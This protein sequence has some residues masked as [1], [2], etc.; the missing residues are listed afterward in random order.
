M[1]FG[2]NGTRCYRLSRLQSRKGL[3]PKTPVQPN[4][5]GTAPITQPGNTARTV[6]RFQARCSAWPC[7]R[8]LEPGRLAQGQALIW[9]D[10]VNPPFDVL[11]L[12]GGWLGREP[13]E[14]GR[15]GWLR[16]R[17]TLISAGYARYAAQ[18]RMTVLRRGE[19]PSTFA[20]F[21]AW[22]HVAHSAFAHSPGRTF[23]RPPSSGS[24]VSCHFRGIPMV[25]GCPN[26][27]GQ[28]AGN[29]NGRDI[30]RFAIPLREP[31]VTFV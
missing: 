21:M 15:E 2:A 5:I 19:V 10:L 18:S 12:S 9:T 13:E 31:M 30:F 29:C 27:C 8:R 6:L 23:L 20:R 28:F 4:Q 11:L 24:R 17:V 7:A 14:D 25:Q 22:A 3:K 1:P 16:R 26:E